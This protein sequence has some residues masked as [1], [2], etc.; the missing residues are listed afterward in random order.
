MVPIC[1]SYSM[2]S[3]PL[4]SLLV[5]SRTKLILAITVSPIWARRSPLMIPADPQRQGHMARHTRGAV[6][7]PHS[8]GDALLHSS[9]GKVLEFQ[10]PYDGT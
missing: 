8:I 6:F 3:I 10:P 7:M 9:S 2:T 5:S 4:S 1:P